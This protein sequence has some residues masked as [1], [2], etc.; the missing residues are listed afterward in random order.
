MAS[1]SIN[2]ARPGQQ[3]PL[4][5]V[6]II[7]CNRFHYLRAT[8]ES[9]HS[10]IQYPR[11]QWIVVDNA[12]VEPGLRDY[13]NQIDWIDELILRDKR[14]PQTEHVEAM[15]E[16]VARAQGD[17][18]LI[19]PEDVQFIVKGDWMT[20]CVEILMAYPL[21]G[22]MGLNCL[23]KITIQSLWTW[24][25]WLTWKGW[26]KEIIRRGFDVRRQ[27]VVYSSLGF[28][29]RTHGWTKPGI[30]GSGIPSLT[31]TEVWRTLG[32][33]RT[34][35]ARPGLVDSSGGG[36]TEM[37]QRYESSGLVLQRAQPILPVAAD[38]VTDPTGTK[39]KVRGNK[40]YGV[41]M[42]PPEGGFYYQIHKQQDVHHLASRSLPISFEELVKPLG[43]SL[44]FDNA[45]NLLKSSINTSVVSDLV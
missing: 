30:I 24:R 3:L 1:K 40:R 2:R 34:P 29:V 6:G 37:L 11:V 21:I 15:N 28:A 18:V 13:L 26:A 23:R 9:A 14:S 16:I 35:G 39:A 12:S 32:P 44:T 19:W 43:Y 10:C 17:L 45:G 4:L 42:P 22:S 31:R 20:D 8:L 38:I 5:T 41:Y 33:W 7:S 36:E 25:R 27:R